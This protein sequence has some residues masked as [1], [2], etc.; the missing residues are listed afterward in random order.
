MVERRRLLDAMA[1]QPGV[2]V[3]GEQYFRILE[4]SSVGCADDPITTSNFLR[5]RVTT[6]PSKGLEGWACSRDVQP[7]GQWVM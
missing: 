1:R 7:T 4:Q 2:L 5:V 3:A 6:G